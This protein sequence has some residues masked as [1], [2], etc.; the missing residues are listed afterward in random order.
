MTPAKLVAS[1]AGLGIRLWVEDGRLR[2]RAPKG[3]LTPELRRQ[4]SEEKTSVIAYLQGREAPRR[5]RKLSP[6]ISN[7]SGSSISWPRRARPTTSR[8]SPGS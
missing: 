1:L 5:P 8:S 3:T 4:I 6:I 7:S 2:Y